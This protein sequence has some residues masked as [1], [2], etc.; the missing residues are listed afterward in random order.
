MKESGTDSPKYRMLIFDKKVNK[1][2]GMENL[3]NKIIKNQAR[4]PSQEFKTDD[5]W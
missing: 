1:G 2:D 4:E 3:P 5:K